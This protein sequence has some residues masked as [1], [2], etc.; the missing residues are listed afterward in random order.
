MQWASWA[1]IWLGLGFAWKWIQ[2]R[3]EAMFDTMLLLLSF[4]LIWMTF[5]ALHLTI[6]QA[7]VVF[8]FWS[9]LIAVI[10][11]E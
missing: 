6:W 5:G 10:K 1:I 11:A 4:G 7:M 2:E 9:A 8:L 3:R